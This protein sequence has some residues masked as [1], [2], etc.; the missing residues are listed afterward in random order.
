MKIKINK[1]L[2]CLRP[3]YRVYKDDESNEKMHSLWWLWFIFNWESNK[4]R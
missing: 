4:K 2:F 1:Y 3:M